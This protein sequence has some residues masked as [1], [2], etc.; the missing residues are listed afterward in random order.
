MDGRPGRDDAIVTADRPATE[1]HL[2]VPDP[3]RWVKVGVPALVIALV[4]VGAV[5][6]WSLLRSTSTPVDVTDAVDRYREE[7]SGQTT[8]SDAASIA[9][10]AEG[11]YVYATEASERVDVLNGA[12]HSYPA[13]TT[14]TIRHT[15]CG[16]EQR[17]TPIEEHWEEDEL[18]LTDEGLE[19]R[20]HFVHHEFF[21]MQDDRE[22]RCEPGYLLLPAD[23]VVGDTWPTSCTTADSTVT[24][25]GEVVGFGTETVDGRAVEVV[26]VRTREQNTGIDEGP[27]VADYWLRRSDGLLIERSAKADTSTDSPVGTANFAGR[28][29]LRLVSLT[30]RT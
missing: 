10:P 21:G 27:S 9:L 30:P 26:H 18:C 13:E 12:D 3:P 5:V 17:W 1:S 14:L 28:Y 16:L 19:R 23:P 25:T 6:A 22:Y 2:H 20:S 8:T 7:G 4:A 15:E 29:S 11:V 24:G